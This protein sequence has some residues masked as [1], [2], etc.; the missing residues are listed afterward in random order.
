MYM[1]L[2][3]IFVIEYVTGHIY[4]A[5]YNMILQGTIVAVIVW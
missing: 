2:I 5:I 4:Y 3:Y 1:Y